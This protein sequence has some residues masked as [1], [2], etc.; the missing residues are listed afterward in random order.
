LLKLLTN[1]FN[2]ILTVPSVNQSLIFASVMY[3]KIVSTSYHS[4]I[5]WV[6][7]ST[8]STRIISLLKKSNKSFPKQL[9]NKVVIKINNHCIPCQIKFKNKY[10]SV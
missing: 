4:A 5:Y 10:D 6:C 2:S 1:N 9:Y 3:D 8:K 7:P